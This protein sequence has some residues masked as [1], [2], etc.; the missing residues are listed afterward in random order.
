MVTLTQEAREELEWWKDHFA[1]WNGRNLIAHNSSPGVRT[2]GPW[3]PH[4]RTMHINCLELLAAHL[5]VKSFAKNKANL[6]IHLKMDS[7]SAIDIHQQTGGNDIPT[8]EL[9]CQRAVAVVYGEEHP[10]QGTTPGRCTEHH[11]RRRVESHER[12][13]RLDAVPGHFPNS[14][15]FSKYRET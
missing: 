4:E 8:A 3:S 11:S 15:S 9:P 13:I 7:M 1:Q 5:A 14:M 6:T 10:S 12:P 2:G